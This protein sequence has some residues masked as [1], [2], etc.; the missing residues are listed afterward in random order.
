MFITCIL[1]SAFTFSK[2]FFQCC[3]ESELSFALLALVGHPARVESPVLGQVTGAGKCFPTE[4]TLIRL[5]SCMSSHVPLQ[6]LIAG[7]CFL[8]EGA[9][10]FIL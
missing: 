3:P 5:F 1:L 7:E 4:F 6:H 2:M 10:K 9:L 8:A